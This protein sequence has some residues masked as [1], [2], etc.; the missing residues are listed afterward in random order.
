[1]ATAKNQV[2]GSAH[3]LAKLT[4]HDVALILQLAAERA[5]LLRQ[6]RELSFRALAEKFEVSESTVQR[7][8]YGER[9][10]HV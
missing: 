3:P 5:E 8:V 6:A 4:E 9:W 2:R 7:I 10:G 1:M